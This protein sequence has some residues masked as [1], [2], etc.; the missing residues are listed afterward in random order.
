MMED[1]TTVVVD[2]CEY[3]GDVIEE[4][5]LVLSEDGLLTYCSDE[6]ALE[7]AADKEE[8]TVIEGNDAPPLPETS[9]NDLPELKD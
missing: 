5:K 6:C 3:C 8:D 9:S 7:D 1:T 2:V 4:D